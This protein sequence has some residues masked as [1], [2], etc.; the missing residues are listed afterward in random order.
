MKLLNF[1][2]QLRSGC[3]LTLTF[4]KIVE[5]FRREFG[6]LGSNE[7]NEVYRAFSFSTRE[8]EDDKE[9]FTSIM[10]YL[11]KLY[12]GID[13]IDILDRNKYISKLV[14]AHL[15]PRSETFMRNMYA[16]Y[17]FAYNN[18]E[19]NS[20]DLFQYMYKYT[21]IL[22]L[23]NSEWIYDTDI[24]AIL[25]GKEGRVPLHI[26]SQVIQTLEILLEKF[27]NEIYMTPTYSLIL[28]NV[29]VSGSTFIYYPST[30]VLE[31]GNKIL[32]PA[33]EN[34]CSLLNNKVLQELIKLKQ[35]CVSMDTNRKETNNET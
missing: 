23:H 28:P 20:Y 8:N 18:I 22:K 2:M 26:L 7:V 30:G 17:V 34:N 10:K 11:C 33:D 3:L 15:K 9:N 5:D 19:L 1:N 13:E 14:N 25:Y 29:V 31:I 4:D 35:I 27:C 12:L 16:L 21:E 24:E 32:V 6:K